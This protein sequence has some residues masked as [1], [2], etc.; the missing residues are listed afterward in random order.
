MVIKNINVKKAVKVAKKTGLPQFFAGNLFIVCI[1]FDRV[2]FL[3]IKIL[4]WKK[5]AVKVAKKTGLP[6]FLL[7]ICLLFNF[8]FR[9]SWFL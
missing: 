1:F 4:T 9:P 3:V 8:S 7:K 6:Q 2:M 5:M